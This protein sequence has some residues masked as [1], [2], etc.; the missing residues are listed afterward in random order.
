MQPSWC[1]RKGPLRPRPVLKAWRDD[2]AVRRGLYQKEVNV[3]TRLREIEA[4]CGGALGAIAAGAQQPLDAACVSRPR[5]QI[6][7][8]MRPGEF[9]KDKVEAPSRRAARTG[10][11]LYPR[12]E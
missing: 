7:V 6:D 12:P 2:P 11:A 5:D 1:F 8:C 10:C 4:R 3:L 9:P